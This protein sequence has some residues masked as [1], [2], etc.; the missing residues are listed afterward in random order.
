MQ[1]EGQSASTSRKAEEDAEGSPSPKSSRLYPPAYAGIKAVEVHGDEDEINT[2]LLDEK[3]FEDMREE[4]AEESYGDEHIMEG[5]ED[6]KAPEVSPE[7]LERIQ[8]QSKSIEVD[9][10]LGIPVMHQFSSEE[11]ESSGGYI[12]STKMV[13]A[14]RHRIEKGGWLVHASTFGCQAVQ[15]QCGHGTDVCTHIHDDCSQVAH[16]LDAQRLQELHGYDVGCERR[17]LDGNATPCRKCFC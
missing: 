6:D 5:E 10:L 12:I 1:V 8:R 15:K 11:V 9:R 7:L 3:F 2:E 4:Y 13:Y 16:S 17:F 14:W